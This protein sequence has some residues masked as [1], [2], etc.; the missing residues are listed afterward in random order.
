[1]KYD[2]NY[3]YKIISSNDFDNKYLLCKNDGSKYKKY[4]LVFYEENNVIK[5]EELPNGDYMDRYSNI[6]SNYEVEEII[7]S[8]IEFDS[9]FKYKKYYK[10]KNK[11]CFIKY[12]YLDECISFKNDNE[13][14]KQLLENL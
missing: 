10:I 13:Q 3:N 2:E 7:S 6:V 8:C 11:L 12:K 4:I 14:V 9:A 1:M 5:S